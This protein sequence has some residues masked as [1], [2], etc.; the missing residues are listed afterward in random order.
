MGRI[1]YVNRDKKG[2]VNSG[3]LR[4]GERLESKNSK[5][6]LEQPID[7]IALILKSDEVRLSAKKSHMLR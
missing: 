5:R 3:L 4:L 7:K 6:E 2:L 1:I